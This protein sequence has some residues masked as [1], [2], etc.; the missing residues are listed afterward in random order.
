M[1]TYSEEALRVLL[2]D[3]SAAPT[4]AGA[5][6]AL[7]LLDTLCALLP[8]ASNTLNEEQRIQLALLLRV[9]DRVTLAA[10]ALPIWSALDRTVFKTAA[11]S[12]VGLLLPLGSATLEIPAVASAGSN[13]LLCCV[14]TLGCL[15]PVVWPSM[16]S[17][18]QEALARGIERG[19]AAAFEQP[20][21]AVALAALPLLVFLQTHMPPS[22]MQPPQGPSSALSSS[23]KGSLV[24]PHLLQIRTGLEHL[25]SSQ[26]DLHH[27]VCTLQLCLA[28]LRRHGA[29]FATWL[30]PSPSP[31]TAAASSSKGVPSKSHTRFLQLL[32]NIVSVE[33]RVV[34]MEAASP[35]AA[36]IAHLQGAAGAQ[37]ADMT[38]ACSGILRWVM[39]GL[40]GEDTD[41]GVTPA[42][43]AFQLWN[44]P[45]DL[46][47]FLK[48]K[49][50]ESFASMLECLIILQHKPAQPRVQRI[51]EA[52]VWA[53]AE[54]MDEDE[55]ATKKAEVHTALP[56]ILSVAAAAAET[57]AAATTASASTGTPD[58]SAMSMGSL[59]VRLLPAFRSLASVPACLPHFL[60]AD[61]P[62]RLVQHI[63]IPEC[64]ST[65]AAMQALRESSTSMEDD[66]EGESAAAEADEA[67]FDLLRHVQH[68]YDGVMGHACAII[69]ELEH[70]AARQPN[71]REQSQLM[72]QMRAQQ[73]KLRPLLEQCMKLAGKRQEDTHAIIAACQSARPIGCCSCVLNALA[74]VCG[75]ACSASDLSAELDLSDALE[76][77][78]GA[79]ELL[80]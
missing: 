15:L 20:G 76:D 65:I 57:E 49:L 74:G 36:D 37:R 17:A 60:Q 39:S 68:S 43:R 55:E 42:T 71:K 11:Q 6:R 23:S 53:L 34:M 72:Q 8:A 5:P 22:T 70:T 50:D 45:Y 48:Q 25:L 52:C 77:M 1:L 26:L 30:L 58:S 12:L 32:L 27:R 78:Q 41:P 33:L 69:T 3:Q 7:P 47:L 63:L 9:L 29:L 75:V 24:E 35:R 79:L 73:E 66:D 38:E 61:F 51:L 10:A 64:E 40:V 16:G 44:L 46:L 80:R 2:Q 59:T 54:W 19:V 18:T 62:Q 31:S 28:L 21:S 67:R 13:L 14:R 4:A 56:L